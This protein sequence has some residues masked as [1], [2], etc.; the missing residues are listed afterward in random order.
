VEFQ[1]IGTGR[2]RPVTDD[3]LLEIVRMLARIEPDTRIASIL[4]RNQR[5]TAHGQEWTAKRICPRRGVRQGR[6]RRTRRHTDHCFAVDSVETV[7]CDAGLCGRT[8]DAA[9]RGRR[10]VRGRTEPSCNPANC[11]FSAVDPRNYGSAET[12]ALYSNTSC[13]RPRVGAILPGSM[14]ALGLLLA[15][16]GLYGVMVYSVARRTR[17][18]GVRVAIGAT[19]GDISR[20]VL[21]DSARLTAIGSAIGL[22]IAVFV[23]KPL[24]VFMVPGLS[25]SDPLNYAV[26]AGVMILTGLAAAWGP[27]RRALAIDPNTA[28]RNE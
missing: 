17:E 22:A 12:P 1:K 4:N 8:L 26:V 20:M 6:R 10:A 27:V 2:H 25:T 24:A 11:R 15:T 21:G 18:I 16:V 13:P 23:T 19:R 3:D 7:A 9:Q 28:L 14:G 5:R